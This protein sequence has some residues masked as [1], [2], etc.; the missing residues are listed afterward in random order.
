VSKQRKSLVVH[1]DPRAGAP[2][3]AELDAHLAD[4]WTIV[5]ATGMGGAA[6]GAAGA[7]QVHF[8][9]LVVLEREDKTTVGGFH[10]S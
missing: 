7:P 8:A 10:G 1:Y 3:T 4:E 6:A 9:A 5:T 2:A